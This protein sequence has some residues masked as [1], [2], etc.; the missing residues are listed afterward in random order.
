MLGLLLEYMWSFN[1]MICRYVSFAKCLVGMNARSFFS[2]F[3]QA[4]SSSM[5]SGLCVNTEL[6]ALM[7][8]QTLKL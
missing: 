5:L 2:G 8:M 7:P 3:G 6:P 4:S 1:I